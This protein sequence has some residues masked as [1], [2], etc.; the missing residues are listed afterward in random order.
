MSSVGHAT[1][2][3]HAAMEWKRARLEFLALPNG[4][5]YTRDYLDNLANAEDNLTKSIKVFEEQLERTEE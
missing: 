4:S 2:I 1:K 5:P 3:I